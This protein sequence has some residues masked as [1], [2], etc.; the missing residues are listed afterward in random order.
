MIETFALAFVLTLILIRVLMPLAVPLGMVDAPGVRKWHKGEIPLIG[1]LAIYLTLALLSLVLPFW[2]AQFGLWLIALGLPLLLIGLVDDR[3]QIAARKRLLIEIGCGLV[4]VFY[5]NIRLYDLGHLLPN[6]GGTLVLLSIP[7][8]IIGMVGVINAVNMTD[9][10]DGLAGGLATLTF[11]ALAFFTY[12]V[13]LPVA[14]QLIT[15]VAVLAGF[16]V[17]NSRFFGRKRAAIFMGSGGSIFIGFAL[18]WYLIMLSQGEGA[19]IRPA[20]ALWLIAVP[21]LDT[22]AIMGR[23]IRD[24]RSPFLPDREHLHHILLLAGFGANRTVL[25]ILAFHLSCILVA[26]A[27]IRFQVREWIVFA[28]SVGVF[29]AYFIGMNHAWKV[30][31]RIKSFSEWAGFEDRRSKSSEGT[32]RIPGLDQ[33]AARLQVPAVKAEQSCSTGATVKDQTDT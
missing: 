5:C 8:T 6:V 3:W 18:A 26:V 21:L 19:V 22:M 10:I 11:G 7:L 2:Q 23:R 31:K 30:M 14:L 25:I 29:A 9:G 1:G 32:G 24:G 20:D 28:L 15:F 13:N 17:F 27:S 4:A 12:P 16:L 33:R